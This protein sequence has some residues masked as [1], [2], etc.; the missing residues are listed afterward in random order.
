MSDHKEKSEDQWRQDLSPE[1]F[2]VCRL[3]ATE[4]AFSGDLLDNKADGTYGCVACGQPLF[5]SSSKFDSGSGWPSFFTPVGDTAVIEKADNSHGMARSE[6]LCSGCE[7][8]L[9]HVFPD[10]PEPSGLRFCVN[11]AA[12]KFTPDK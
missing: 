12:L 4:P 3:G 11:S 6:V 10:G 9:G 1:A 5:V 2:A 7:S 8:H